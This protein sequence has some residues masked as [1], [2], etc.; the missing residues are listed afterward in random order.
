MAENDQNTPP[1]GDEANFDASRAWTLIQNLRGENAQLKEDRDART[2]ERD[3]AIAERDQQ[4]SELNER[5]D[6]LQ[7]TVQLT[8]DT[9]KQHEQNLNAAQSTIAKH[10]LLAEAGL[11]LSLSKNLVGDSEDEWTESVQALAGLKN[12]SGPERRPDPAQVAPPNDGLSVHDAAAA[13]F[14]NS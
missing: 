12:Q 13:E 11:P 7:A 6:E 8:D 5:V 10:S 9:A 4:V 1:W 2:S 3:A 14:F